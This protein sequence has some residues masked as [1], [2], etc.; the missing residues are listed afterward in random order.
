MNDV[1]LN[2]KKLKKFIKFEIT[3][4]CIYGRDRGYT[5]KEILK[6]LEFADQ[7]FKTAILILALLITNPLFKKC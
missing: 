5:D 2:W 7:R 1:I 3:D 4:N 6:I